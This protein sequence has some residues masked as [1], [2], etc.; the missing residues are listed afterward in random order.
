MQGKG[1]TVKVVTY[2]EAT[3]RAELRTGCVRAL[4][5]D[6]SVGLSSSADID[7]C[8]GQL[9]TENRECFDVPP[10]DYP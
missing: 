5:P 7:C 9:E 6:Y 10:P 1:Q 4:V 2:S 3:D 8:Q